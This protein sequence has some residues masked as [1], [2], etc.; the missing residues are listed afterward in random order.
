VSITQVLLVLVGVA[1][2]WGVKFALPDAS[3]IAR[4]GLVFGGSLAVFLVALALRKP[5]A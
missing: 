1:L 5:N 2:W 3:F 4:L